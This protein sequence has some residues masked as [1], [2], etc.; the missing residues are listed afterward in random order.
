MMLVW[1]LWTLLCV[2]VIFIDGIRF[3]GPIKRWIPIAFVMLILRLVYLPLDSQDVVGHS[4]QYLDVFRGQFPTIGDSTFYPALQIVWFL[5][6][7]VS[8][9]S[10]I[11][12]HSV[13]FLG[14]V[15]IL[16]L[17]IQI[18]SPDS[19]DNSE[20]KW[21]SMVWLLVL[22]EH[23]FWSHSMYNVMFPFSMLA[24]STVRLAQTKR[25]YV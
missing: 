7:K 11:L 13:Q 18:E 19:G 22:P 10:S 15:S 4:V 1:W 8:F 17:S 20:V 12:G 6:G 16:W 9:W 14:V 23:V 25:W 3:L 24:L 5:F 21:L 2:S